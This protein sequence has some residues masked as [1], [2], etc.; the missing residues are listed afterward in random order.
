M[1]S[2][3][4]ELGPDP[5]TNS[6]LIPFFSFPHFLFLTTTKDGLVSCG[7]SSVLWGKTLLS[8]NWAYLNQ[9]F[10]LVLQQV[11]WCFQ[12]QGNL[13]ACHHGCCHH[14]CCGKTIPENKIPRQRWLL[15]CSVD[16]DQRPNVFQDAQVQLNDIVEECSF[17]YCSCWWS[18]NGDQLQQHQKQ[19]TYVRNYTR[20]FI[21]SNFCEHS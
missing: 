11:H 4:I 15:T 14:C 20:G 13:P 19:Q 1:L 6:W 18:A 17:F 12:A 10:C 9:T 21:S 7:D 3:G 5:G 2:P 16:T 8:E